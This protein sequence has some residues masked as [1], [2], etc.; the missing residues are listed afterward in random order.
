MHDVEIV[1]VIQSV[2]HDKPASN[3]LDMQIFLIGHGDVSPTELSTYPC[4][5]AGEVPPGQ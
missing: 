3:P 5:R 2:G 1:A 4:R